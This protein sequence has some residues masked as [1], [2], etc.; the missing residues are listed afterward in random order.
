MTMITE[1]SDDDESAKEQLASAQSMLK[2][3]NI[4]LAKAQEAAEELEAIKAKYGANMA[5]AAEAVK[6]RQQVTDLTRENA[7]LVDEKRMAIQTT[8]K[9]SASTIADLR[10]GQELLKNQ[11][12]TQ[13]NIKAAEIAKLTQELDKAKAASNDPARQKEQQEL[14][15]LRADIKRLTSEQKAQEQQAIARVMAAKDTEVASNLDR[16]KTK[17]DAII[18]G[19]DEELNTIAQRLN[20]TTAGLTQQ[21]TQLEELE[22]ELTALRVKNEELASAQKE[23]IN[24]E[25]LQAQVAQIN[26]YEA[27]ML[28][29]IEDKTLAQNNLKTL[30]RA[31]E[32]MRAESKTAATRETELAKQLSVAESKLDEM[33]DQQERWQRDQ[34]AVE[35]TQKKVLEARAETDRFKKVNSELALAIQEKVKANATLTAQVAQQKAAID[36]LDAMAK[37]STSSAKDLKVLA[38]EN[39]RLSRMIAMQKRRAGPC[40][41]A[42]EL[43]LIHPQRRLPSR[44][45]QQGHSAGGKHNCRHLLRHPDAL[46]NP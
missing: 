39:D 26:E 28:K 36:Q 46:P 12:L 8:L 19:K 18:A 9:N 13:A 32:T 30:G 31:I 22:D 14:A 25:S 35:E 3:Q 24:N 16:M 37:S 41:H 1:K 20:E 11:L 7:E 29:A 5:D 43:G 42:S 38:E 23:M 34:F 15:Q 6:L 2:K 4:E 21:K 45:H 17:Y 33:S 27:R 44:H 40:N 10:Q